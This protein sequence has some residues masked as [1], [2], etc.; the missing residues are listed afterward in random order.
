MQGGMGRSDEVGAVA[1]LT[2]G[3]VVSMS[4]LMLSRDF[5]LSVLGWGCWG[6]KN[7]AWTKRVAGEAEC[8]IRWD[9]ILGACLLRLYFGLV[10]GYN[11]I[12]ALS[13]AARA[14]LLHVK[15][16]LQFYRVIV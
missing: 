5:Q 8:C 14:G 13:M 15:I 10:V 7:E 2:K 3:V 1:L 6:E 16:F 4:M 11:P 12:R 9:E